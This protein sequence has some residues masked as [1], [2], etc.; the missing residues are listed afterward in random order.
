MPNDVT[1]E[2]IEPEI[3]A[4]KAIVG[5]LEPLEPE[6]ARRVLCAVAVILGFDDMATQMLRQLRAA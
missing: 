3:Q 6:Q 2:S 1:R 4:M 5:A